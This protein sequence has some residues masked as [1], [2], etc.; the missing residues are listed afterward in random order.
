MVGII[1]NVVSAVVLVGA[2]LYI[3]SL[4]SQY[5]A[6]EEDYFDLA[7]K[8][9]DLCRENESLKREINSLQ[10]ENAKLSEAPK[11]EKI[12]KPRKTTTRKTTKK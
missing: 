2:I 12:T 7:D 6:L 4:K 1:I 8:D 9:T 3:F 5:N 11:V 10:K